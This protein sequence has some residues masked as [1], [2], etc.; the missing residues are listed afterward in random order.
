MAPEERSIPQSRHRFQ[1]QGFSYERLI[2]YFFASNAGLTIV[3]LV[4]IIVFLI[5]EP[6]GL[7]AI[8]T[9]VRRFFHLWP[10]KT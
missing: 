10:F 6:H 4:L 9:R 1:R 2:K 3:I 8:W 5:F 7:A